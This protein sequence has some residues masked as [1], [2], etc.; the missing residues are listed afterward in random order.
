[1][2]K[3]SDTVMAIVGMILSI[4]LAA[5]IEGVILFFVWPVVIPATFPGLVSMGILA[6]KLSIWVS[7]CLTWVFNILFKPIKAQSK[8]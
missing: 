2:N 3:T 8:K 7:I 5:S 6:P 4:F 1:M